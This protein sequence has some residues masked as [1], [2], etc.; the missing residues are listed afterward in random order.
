MD[1]NRLTEVRRTEQTESRI[2]EDFLEWLKSTGLTLLVIVMVLLVGYMLYVRWDSSRIEHRNNAWIEYASSETA[3]LP[4]GFLAVAD[5]Y[6]DVDS[7]ALLARIQAGRAWLEAVQ[8]GRPLDAA[9]GSVATLSEDD[10]DVYLTRAD[11]AFRTVLSKDDKSRGM[12]L[13]MISALNGRAAV[14]EARGE[15]EE[16]KRFY[17]EAA[18][19][20]G[21]DYPHLRDQA[22]RRAETAAAVVEAPDLPAQEDIAADDGAAD[23]GASPVKLDDSL[24]DLLLT[25]D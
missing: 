24:R 11:E 14:A 18:A 19:R 1:R 25:E 5:Q 16:A 15:I 20:A 7:V 2:N 3:G 12:A 22:E 10:R 8:A 6:G 9:A 21:D 23:D 13:L 4:S 17:G